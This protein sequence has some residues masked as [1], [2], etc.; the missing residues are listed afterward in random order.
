MFSN[1]V[2]IRSDNL[3]I[4]AVELRETSSGGVVLRNSDS[5]VD[6]I[7]DG[8]VL[9]VVPKAD[10]PCVVI[11]GKDELYRVGK[12]VSAG[13]RTIGDAET[14]PMFHVGTKGAV[15][16]VSIVD[17]N[18]SQA[19]VDRTISDF[20]KQ[21]VEAKA[22]REVQPKTPAPKQQPPKPRQQPQPPKRNN[23]PLPK[24]ASW[25]AKGKPSATL[26]FR[27][28]KQP[29]LVE[30]AVEYVE[31]PDKGKAKEEIIPEK[32][33]RWADAEES[34]DFTQ[35]DA[36]LAK[37]EAHLEAGNG[38][39]PEKSVS[40]AQSIDASAVGE[41]LGGTTSTVATNKESQLPSHTT[42]VSAVS[43]PVSHGRGRVKLGDLKGLKDSKRT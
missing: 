8:A 34:M 17:C 33:G 30:R 3:R 10:G 6:I 2:E 24:Q 4:I 7:F 41:K 37:M 25:A 27:E 19:Q 18:M 23:S 31:S 13:F 5:E 9:T 22:E 28:A 1:K 29:L 12:G 11:L 40:L 20:K 39:F 26:H 32:S 14:M 36:F 15:V 35:A 42:D 38:A 21:K 43:S 16:D